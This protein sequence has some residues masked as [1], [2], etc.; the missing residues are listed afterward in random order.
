VIGARSIKVNWPYMV[1]NLAFPLSLLF[2]VGIL[3]QGKL[4]PF[5]LVGGLLSIIAMNGITA[6]SYLGSLKF[7]YIYQDLIMTTKT[8][9]ID[10]MFAHLLGELVWIIPSVVL[11]FVL[12]IIFSILTPY[13]FLMTLFL[14]ALVSVATYSISFWFSG[15][16]KNNRYTPA[17]G[18]VLGLLMITLPPTFYPYTYLPKSALYILTFIP[19]TPAVILAQGVFGIAPMQWY[20]LPVLIIET[21]AYFL[22]AKYLTKWRED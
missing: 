16:V 13:T 8:S 12:D 9:K 4:L 15:V 2:V 3:S 17:I 21:L 18:T 19:T 1:S 14:G 5:A 6:V 11:Y 10:Y 22:I 7:D 20:M